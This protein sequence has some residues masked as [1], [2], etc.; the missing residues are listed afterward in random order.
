L[1]E[2]FSAGE[3][4]TETGIQR[5]MVPW[6]AGRAERWIRSQ[7]QCSDFSLDLAKRERFGKEASEFIRRM[8]EGK[9]VRLEFDPTNAAQGRNDNTQ[10]RRTLAYVFLADGMR[11]N[12]EIIH[13]GYGLSS[14]H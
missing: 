5:A 13:E 7:A 3:E 9:R 6:Y 10:Q 8:V 1:W 11:L 12:A 14:I 2:Q 4:K